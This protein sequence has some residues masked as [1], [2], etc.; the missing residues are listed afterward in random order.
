MLFVDDEPAVRE[1]GRTVLER[2]GYQPLVATDGADALLKATEQRQ[3]LAAVVTDLHMPHLDGLAFLRALRRSQPDMPVIV[4]S[5]RVEESVWAEL[6]S[7][8]VQQRLDKPFTQL[9]LANALG[10]VLRP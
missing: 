9:Q 4:A 8:G 3:H 2:L 1:V 7:L 10:A 5:G 6:Q